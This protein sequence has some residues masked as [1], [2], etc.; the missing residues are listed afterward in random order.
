M[1]AVF[2]SWQ[3]DRPSNVNRSFLEDV[4]NK[5]IA[6]LQKQVAIEA[7]QRDELH[8]LDKDTKGVPGTPEIVSTIFSKIE[9]CAAFVADMTFVA[10]SEEGRCVPNPNVLIEYGW[11]LAKVG[12]GRILTIC[13][14]HFG[15]VTESNLPFDMRHLRWP[16][17]YTLAPDARGDER[18][19]VRSE[20]IKLMTEAIAGVLSLENSS[21]EILNPPEFPLLKPKTRVSSF[22]NEGDV[23]CDLVPFGNRSDKTTI[24]WNDG[25]QLFLRVE[26][27]RA[28]GPFTPRQL[29]TMMKSNQHQLLPFG[30]AGGV[31]WEANELGAVTLEAR[32]EPQTTA[33]RITQVSRYGEIWGVNGS[34]LRGTTVIPFVEPLFI[35][36]LAQYWR[37]AI[38]A[39]KVTPPL[40]VSAGLTGVRGYSIALP[41]PPPGKFYFEKFIGNCVS[42]S[43]SWSTELTR[44]NVDVAE[45]LT[46]FFVSIWE[47]CNVDRPAHLFEQKDTSRG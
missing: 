37:F 6:N 4:L 40:A 3:S 31:W 22:L 42:D 25:P 5:A 32:G 10:R 39:L 12:R 35:D 29:V 44:E 2:Y 30:N 15:H 34:V 23:L 19:E 16:I 27:K 7:A 13:N 26:P 38:D 20:L 41:S 14:E 18:K 46:P 9:A 21:R 11:A 33:N 28:V 47:H 17:R 43:I 36:A 24:T 1:A 8:F 45:I